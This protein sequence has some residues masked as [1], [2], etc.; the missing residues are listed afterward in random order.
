MFVIV[1]WFNPSESFK[2]HSTD[3]I[4]FREGELRIDWSDGD[5]SL[6]K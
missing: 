6:M 4:W 2:L 5:N 1:E 3:Y